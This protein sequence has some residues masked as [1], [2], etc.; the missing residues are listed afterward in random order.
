MSKHSKSCTHCASRN[1]DRVTPR[2]GARSLLSWWLP[3]VDCRCYSCGEEWS[4]LSGPFI[5]VRRIVG[6]SA[7]AALLLFWL[8]PKI[9]PSTPDA[10]P[11][12]VSTSNPITLA[13]A[14]Q[15]DN[16]IVIDE[17]R[18]AR[19]LR[20]VGAD[21]NLAISAENRLA[22]FE[23]LLEATLRQRQQSETALRQ[24]DAYLSEIAGQLGIN[25]AD[26][27]RVTLGRIIVANLG[28]RR[29]VVAGELIQPAP[30]D[31]PISALAQTA[32]T[33]PAVASIEKQ[34]VNATDSDSLLKQAT[35][36]V[37]S[38]LNEWSS[39]WS[40]RQLDAYVLAYADDYSRPGESRDQWLRDRRRA[41]SRPAW[42]RI[43][44]DNPQIQ[45][46]GRAEANVKFTQRY[47]SNRYQ[48]QT[49]KQ[50][51]LRKVGDAWKIVLEQTP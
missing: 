35:A 10:N 32:D 11:K 23:L 9:V 2:D 49:V 22:Q 36:E 14:Q 30:L 45:L 15:T 1:V 7:V 5:S 50:L 17:A 20:L 6:W 12:A 4:D 13:P 31:E 43:E 46:N 18:M 3:V 48:D 24:S 34:P 16:G 27:D 25:A 37:N 39:A 42:I 40:N 47:S 33:A 38:A 21:D 41:L 28:R 19:L 26:F 29:P 8:L 51:R 44:L